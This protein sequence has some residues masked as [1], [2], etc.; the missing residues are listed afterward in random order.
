[1]SNLTIKTIHDYEYL[2][3][4]GNNYIF[5]G[6][7]KECYHLLPGAYR[8]ENTI[9]IL[10]PK[11]EIDCIQQF[12]QH[13]RQRG[14]HTFPD[15]INEF[16]T[17][18]TTS[19]VFPTDDML[20][21]LAIAQHYACDSEYKWLKTSLLDVSYSL[22]IATYFA[23]NKSFEFNGKIFIFD[24]DKITLPYKIYE[25]NLDKRKEAR[26]IVQ[27]GAFI[28]RKQ[29]YAFEGEMFQYKEFQPFDDIVLD[30]IIITNT[31]KKELKKHLRIKLFDKV[32]LPKLIL[33]P[34]LPDMSYTGIKSFEEVRELHKHDI[35]MCKNAG[36]KHSIY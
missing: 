25:P 2:P 14:Y 7:S 32:L 8:P 3:F 22:D 4:V 13:L 12:I 24:K 6:H 16:N 23:V 15:D 28:Y 29:E 21:Y 36:D 33:G 5:R 20:P 1:M 10:G 19:R 26:M 30:T 9:K 34:M 18:S 17:F 31:L 27:N 35:E 11:F